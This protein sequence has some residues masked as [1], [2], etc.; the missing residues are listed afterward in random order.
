MKTIILQICR[1]GI[2]TLALL[3]LKV[4]AEE[5][6]TNYAGFHVVLATAQASYPVGASVIVTVTMTNGTHDS[7]VWDLPVDGC[8]CVFGYFEVK[9]LSA[10]TNLPCRWMQNISRSGHEEVRQHPGDIS[11][12]VIDLTESHGLKNPG[13][14]SVRLLG[15]MPVPIVLD[16]NEP[17]YPTPPL[18]I[19]ITNKPAS[20]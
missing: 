20:N 3:T 7:V 2:L 14:Y 16:N 11:K 4:T 12:K 1:Y 18:I 13:V 5:V 6:Q 9:S 10:G 15:R 8:S 19:T 17:T